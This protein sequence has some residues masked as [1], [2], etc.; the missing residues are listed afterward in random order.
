MP[1][2][3]TQSIFIHTHDCHKLTWN[4]CQW[5]DKCGSCDR[6]LPGVCLASLFQQLWKALLHFS[7]GPA[8][9][10]KR[11][12]PPCTEGTSPYLRCLK[13]SGDLP[14]PSCKICGHYYHTQTWERQRQHLM[15]EMCLYSYN[16][17]HSFV[18][19][20]K[21]NIFLCGD[22]NL[23]LLQLKMWAGFHSTSFRSTAGCAVVWLTVLHGV[24]FCATVQQKLT[25]TTYI[26]QPMTVLKQ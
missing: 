3:Y 25:R 26:I 4:I 8:V 18:A 19:I 20:K 12:S 1:L 9:T 13:V 24:M 2:C 23:M 10:S 6:E 22:L 21:W 17:L 14:T 5:Q 7:P 11:W 15:Q 16:L